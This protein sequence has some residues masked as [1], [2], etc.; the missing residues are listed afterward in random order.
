MFLLQSQIQQSILPTIVVV[1]AFVIVGLGLIFLIF[2]VTARQQQNKLFLRQQMMQQEFSKQLMQSQIEVQEHTSAALSKE[3]HDNIGQLLSATKFLLA[4]TGRQMD[5]VPETLKTAEETVAKAIVDLRS[6]SKSLDRQWLKSFN[7]VENLRSETRRINA[8]REISLQ[9]D[10][11]YEELP[12]HPE[13]Q[14]MLFRVI[15]E[16][17]QNSIKHGNAAKIDVRIIR[18]KNNCHVIIQDDGLG[19]EMSAIARP[20]LGI[21]NMR[22]RIELLHGQITWSK[23]GDRGT[24][25]DILLTTA[26][27]GFT[28]D[29][30]ASA[31]KLMN[32]LTI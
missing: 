3:L 6:L 32:P 24:T 15:Q 18:L 17:L 7:L 16:A 29:A 2:F 4:V 14:V 22:D 12:L 8:A 13:S 28:D 25:V 1:A 11:D 10:S 9:F 31:E 27:N 23:N 19:F 21:R 20:G 30:E 26:E 5:V